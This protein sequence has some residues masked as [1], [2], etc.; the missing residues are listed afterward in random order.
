MH[1]PDIAAA[2]KTVLMEKTSTG[3]ILIEYVNLAPC[4]PDYFKALVSQPKNGSQK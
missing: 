2:G 4:P 3:I 1:K